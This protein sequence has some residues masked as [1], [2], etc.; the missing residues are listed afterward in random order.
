[1]IDN[2]AYNPFAHSGNIVYGEQ[3]VG[4]QE[5]IKT[6]QQRVIN[7]SY[8]GCLAIV[9]SPRIGKSSLVYHALIYPQVSL[10]DKKI[11]TFWISLPNFRNYEEVFRGLVKNTLDVLDDADLKDER[12]FIWGQKLLEKDLVWTDLQHE[13]GNFFRKIKSSGW[14]VVSVI[15]EFDE[16]RYIFQDGVGFLALR[17]LAYEPQYGVTIVTT[18]RRPLREITKQCRQDV[19][20]FPL[21]FLDE[22]LKCF[23]RDELSQL[24]DKLK[25][26][27]LNV[28]RNIFDFIWDNAGGH[29]YLASV[30][31]F[32]ISNRWLQSNQYDLEKALTDSASEFLKYYDKL[33]ELLKEDGSFDKTLLQI[34]FGPVTRETILNA[35]QLERYGLIEKNESGHYSAFSE[36]F[37]DY[38]RWASRSKSWWHLWDKTEER[39]RVLID[40][41]LGKQYQTIDWITALENAYPALKHDV[42]DKCHEL[43]MREQRRFGSRALVT[44]IDFTNMDDLGKII[45]QHWS[46]FEPILGNNKDYWYRCLQFLS[47]VRN[48]LAYNRSNKVL[49]SY[50]LQK[51]EDYCQE[52]LDLLSKPS[53]TE[54]SQKNDKTYSRSFIINAN[55]WNHYGDY[56][57][58]DKPTIDARASKFGGGLAAGNQTGGTLNDYS[59][60]FESRPTLAEAAEEIQQ[61]LRQLAENNPDATEIEQKQFVT[62]R[63]PAKR[64]ER[65][66]NAL[67]AGGQ[68]AIEEFLDNPYVNVAI[69][70]IEGWKEGN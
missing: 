5:A 41:I 55:S 56:M 1:M 65:F 6:I 66:F 21:I 18:S 2:N 62:A 33:F 58:E 30:L 45:S 31:L 57:P 36:H 22:Y 9:G 34:L 43:Q 28:H 35:E 70:I 25:I 59:K 46:L 40:K 10:L 39:I 69:S 11:L 14:R 19:S 37:E 53:A 8:P 7:T 29:P 3:F 32:K 4:R 52:I 38:L 15:D 42:F 67:K 13:V 50:E 44:L 16:A 54:D 24:L 48:P 61:L 68:A 12:F 51:A 63:I 47:T 17:H 64:R 23:S 20:T 49:A 60:T 27:G 26:I